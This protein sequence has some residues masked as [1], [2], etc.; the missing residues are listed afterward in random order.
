MQKKKENNGLKGIG[1]SEKM[2]WQR[3]SKPLLL[4]GTLKKQRSTP[5]R[6]MSFVIEWES[7]IG[8]HISH[9]SFKKVRQVAFQILNAFC[10]CFGP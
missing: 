6:K 10:L 8:K 1:D 5:T 4:S 9:I 7:K 2:N 3:T